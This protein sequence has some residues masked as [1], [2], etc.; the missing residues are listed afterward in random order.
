MRRLQVP[1]CAPL[2]PVP[3]ASRQPALRGVQADRGKRPAPPAIAGSCLAHKKTTLQK[4]KKKKIAGTVENQ[5]VSS[6]KKESRERSNK[7]RRAQ[8]R[9]WLTVLLQGTIVG[10]KVF[11]LDRHG[12]DASKLLRESERL[13]N[14][15]WC[16][17]RGFSLPAA[18]REGM[19]LRG[20]A[21]ALNE[22]DCALK[23]DEWRCF[24]S[25]HLCA[26]VHVVAG[27]SGSE[28]DGSDGMLGST[29]SC[30]GRRDHL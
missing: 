25:R 16:A 3:V 12:S 15:Q 2:P 22:S 26:H 10:R 29:C 14:H 27:R 20:R 6:S 1:V 21:F 19:Q 30:C 18:A 23:V 28:R 5:V 4:K 11:G 13:Q 17:C 8:H 24:Q 9:M 7:N